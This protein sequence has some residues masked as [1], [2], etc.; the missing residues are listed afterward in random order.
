MNINNGLSEE[1]VLESREKNGS[2]IITNK[3]RNTFLEM[4]IQS[5]GDPIIRILIIA[6]GIKLVF[7]IKDFDWYETV[8]IVIAI[9]LAS[10]ISTISEYGSEKAFEKLQ[11]DASKIKCRVRRN[12]K[13]KEITID[14]VVVGDMVLLEAGDKVP[15]DGILIDGDLLVDESSLNGETREIRK[16]ALK[17]NQ[18]V[19]EK[20]M[21]FRGTVIYGKSGIMKIT[22]VGDN[23]FYGKIAQELQ[24]S[25][26]DSPLKIL[27]LI[28]I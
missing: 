19:S 13:I 4:F 12:G 16:E 28:H 25:T 3:K 9:F 26:P 18:I 2:N 14:D 22:K 24:E 1:E 23:T 10:F 20:N 7:L 15:A 27:S 21:V 6:L 5:L 8:G 11:E 17:S